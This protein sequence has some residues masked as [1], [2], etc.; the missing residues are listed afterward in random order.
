MTTLYQ[1]AL[2]NKDSNFDTIESTSIKKIKEWA[3]GRG[4]EYTLDIDSVFNIMNGFDG[5]KTFKVKNDR[6]YLI[7][8]N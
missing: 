5:S 8:A 2:A 7:N 1:A 6:F 4:G 3:K